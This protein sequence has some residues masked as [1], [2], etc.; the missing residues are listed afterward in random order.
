MGNSQ[1]STNNI[2][3]VFGLMQSIL[4][5]VND[6]S[7]DDERPTNESACYDDG[8]AFNDELFQDYLDRQRDEDLAKMKS[9]IL[10]MHMLEQDK[11][12]IECEPPSKRSRRVKTF[13]D[14]IT[15]LASHFES[16][17]PASSCSYSKHLWQAAALS[18]Q[19]FEL[20]LQVICYKAAPFQ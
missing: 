11:R 18:Y 9:R 10:L 20:N 14:P 12:E 19:R 3:H 6:K 7:A 2:S 5:S 17:R 16:P 4:T 15:H 8:G 1:S 13:I